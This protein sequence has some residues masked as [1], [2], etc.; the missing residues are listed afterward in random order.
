VEYWRL[1]YLLPVAVAHADRV[2]E[3][4]REQILSGTI[5]TGAWLGE[6][7]LAREFGVSRTPIRE[8][9]KR[10]LAEGLLTQTPSRGLVVASV[11]IEDL[12]ALYSV[13]E[14]L[15]GV[16]A[17]ACADRGDSNLVTLLRANVEAMTIAARRGSS[18]ELTHMNHQFHV[19]LRQGAN[20]VYLD[21]FL[22]EIDHRLS[23]FRQTTYELLGRADEAIGEHLA[24]VDA[25]SRRDPISAE[26]AALTHQRNAREAR[27]RRL[28]GL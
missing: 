20:N 13:R 27:V 28:I 9:L 6:V 5:A 25:I 10:L 15:E 11:S 24:L 14:A 22:T 26:A 23:Q 16:A 1:L 3:S 12:Q 8:A 7:A 17:R 21:K 19:L 18:D 2:T 4:L